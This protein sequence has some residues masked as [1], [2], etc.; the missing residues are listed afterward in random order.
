MLNENHYTEETDR[1]PFPFDNKGPQTEVVMAEKGDAS[2][3]TFG[4][5]VEMI[6]MS[7]SIKDPQKIAPIGLETLK[8]QLEKRSNSPRQEGFN[9]HL[10]TGT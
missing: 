6:G 2:L 4:W 8:D 5:W 1:F 10:A 3:T 9:P 7:K